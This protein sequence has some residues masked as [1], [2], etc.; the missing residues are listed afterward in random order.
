MFTMRFDMRAP[1]RDRAGVADLY[2]AAIDMAAWADDKG[3]AGIAISEHHASEDGYLPSPLQLAAAMAAVTSRTPIMIAAALLPLYDPVRLAE[4]MI[5]LDHLSR[6]R[7]VYTFAIGYRPVEYELH[8]ADYTRRA[9]VAEEKLATLLDVLRAADEGSAVPRVTPPPYTPGGPTVFLGGGSKAAARRAGR[10]GMNFLSQSWVEE[11][12][13]I[14]EA[15]ARAHGH[16]PG[17][18]IIPSRDVPTAVFVNDDLDAGWREVGPALL[19]DAVPYAEWNEAAGMADTTVSISRARTLE[20]LRAE[21]G[22][23]R[24][25]TVAEAV[26]LVRAHGYLPLV[27]LCGGLDPDVGWRYLRRVVEE[28]LP[29]AT[30]G[31]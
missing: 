9:A 26:E 31:R 27:P 23:R 8:G 6:G 16:E 21:R 15:S 13:D 29:A 12:R 5:V 7:V 3:C 4:D 30:G 24:V 14:Y 18:C 22:P 19:A 25:V 1:G 10:L 28:V 20:E 11:L 2:R 17:M